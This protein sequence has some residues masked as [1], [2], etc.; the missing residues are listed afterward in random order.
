MKQ[1]TESRLIGISLFIAGV[2]TVL[3]G[4]AVLA[5]STGV[6][7]G[8]YLSGWVLKVLGIYTLTPEQLETYSK[9]AFELGREEREKE[10]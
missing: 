2:S 9:E 4:H 1:K 5:F 8:V 6:V 3:T 10:Q 7:T